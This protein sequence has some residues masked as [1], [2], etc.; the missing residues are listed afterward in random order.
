MLSAASFVSCGVRSPFARNASNEGPPSGHEHSIHIV[1]ARSRIAR[2]MFVC[3][4]GGPVIHLV[5][6]KAELE[7]WPM[8][9]AWGPKRT[10]KL[11]KHVELCTTLFPDEKTCTHWAKVVSEGRSAGRPVT[12]ADGWIAATAIQWELPLVTADY[13]DFEQ[14]EGLTLVP[15]R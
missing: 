4:I 13:R 12:T 8:Q 11:R 7:V 15:V 1:Q 14:I 10:A 6:T 5:M 3:G 9:N 2:S